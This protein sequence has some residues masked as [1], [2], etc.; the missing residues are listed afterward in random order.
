MTV[1]HSLPVARAEEGTERFYVRMAATFIAVAVVGF[2]PT[3]WMPMARGT[4]AVSPIVHIHGLLFLG[5]TLLFWAQTSLAARGNMTRHRELGVA[6]V[7][8]ATAMCFVGMAV[9]VHSLKQAEAAGFGPA[10]RA[11]S[12][13][14]VTAILLFAVLVTIALMNVKR[15]DLHKRLMLVATASLLQAG[16]GRWFALFFRPAEAVGPPPVAVT[17]V[18]GLVADLLIIAGMMHDRRTRGRVHPVYW[19]AGAAVVA[20]QVLRVPLSTTA[21][22][23]RVTDWLLAVGI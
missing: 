19:I 6:G 2:A 7:S 11:F 13:I 4:L 22:W 23:T 8:V 15:A 21:A 9:T 3:Y 5:W 14:S 12:V 16:I 18:P 1:A 10:G 17:V 20:V